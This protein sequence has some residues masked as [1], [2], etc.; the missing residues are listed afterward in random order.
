MI[1]SCQK[2]WLFSFFSV[3]L[4]FRG[5]QR[6]SS[7]TKCLLQYKLLLDSESRGYPSRHQCVGLP[8]VSSNQSHMRLPDPWGQRCKI[9]HKGTYG[10]ITLDD[11][12]DRVP[13]S[14]M[15]KRDT[16]LSN[17]VSL[18]PLGRPWDSRDP[19]EIRLIDSN[20]EFISYNTYDISNPNEICVCVY[21]CTCTCVSVCVLLREP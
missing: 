4:L 19:P 7:P 9:N 8:T 11:D 1:S 3:L 6:F 16:T 13:C 21:V 14:Q 15:V 2:N 10:R 20:N 12:P 5:D 17:I 18:M